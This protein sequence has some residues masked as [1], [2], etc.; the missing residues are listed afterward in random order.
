[1]LIYR[2]T[3]GPVLIAAIILLAWLDQWIEDRTEIAGV[4]FMPVVVAACTGAAIELG[5]ILS[6]AGIGTSRYITVA[7]ALAGLVVSSFTKDDIAGRSGVALVSTVGAAVLLVAMLYYSKTKVLKGVTAASGAALLVFVYPGLLAG[8]YIVIR[9]EREFEHGM[10][11]VLA[12]VL[13]VKMCDT[14][15]FFVGRAIG[16]TKLIPWVSPGKTWEGLVGGV[17][18]SAGV[19]VALVAIARSFEIDIPL[20]L[21][22]AAI[23]GVVLGLVGQGGDLIASMLKRD[24]GRKDASG[25][26]PGF[27]GVLDVLDSLLFAAPV[28]Y[29][30]LDT[31]V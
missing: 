11:L 19:A 10:W 22:D 28:A 3:L 9:R 20:T 27:G 5:R 30:T 2:L 12:V 24:A 21:L 17:A 8:F 7:A 14:G 16:R 1:M 18:T 15:A 29:W 4:I 25:A 26:L 23:A 13:I 6:A 31:L